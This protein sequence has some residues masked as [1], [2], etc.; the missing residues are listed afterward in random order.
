M[1]NGTRVAFV[2]AMKNHSHASPKDDRRSKTAAFAKRTKTFLT[3]APRALADEV[4]AHPY[5]ALGVAVVIGF[6]GGA[7]VGSRILRGA[8]ASFV[9]AALMEVARYYVRTELGGGRRPSDPSEATL[10]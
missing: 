5:R 3:N 8:V 1:F 10:S 7:I 6:G 9:G 2:L 4:T